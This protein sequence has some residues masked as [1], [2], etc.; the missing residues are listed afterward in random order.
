[1]KTIT[2]TEERH[3]VLEI[4]AEAMRLSELE[5]KHKAP[6]T[7]CIEAFPK[8]GT[9]QVLNEQ[10]TEDAYY[11]LDMLENDIAPD[12]NPVIFESLKALLG[13]NAEVANRLREARKR[14]ARDLILVAVR[15]ILKTQ[16]MAVQDKLLSDLEK[17]RLI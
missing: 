7:I 12:E 16:S 14:K 13:G 5:K 11:W 3:K 2:I 15:D 4:F 10:E 17:L 6:S 9:Y 1:M 8:P